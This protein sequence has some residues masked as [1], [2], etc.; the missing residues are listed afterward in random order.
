MWC[1]LTE[2]NPGRPGAGVGF[3][4]AV[5]GLGRRQQRR[6]V[7]RSGAG[8]SGGRRRLARCRGRVADIRA[9]PGPQPGGPGGEGRGADRGE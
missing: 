4:P 9:G 1:Y 7:G 8:E 5:S 3:L 6:L 2:L